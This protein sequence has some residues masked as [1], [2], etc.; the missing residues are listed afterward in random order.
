M[1]QE[2]EVTDEKYPEKPDESMGDCPFAPD[3]GRSF[4]SWQQDGR[5][6]PIST[7]W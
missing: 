3:Y 1:F 5:S 6:G 7:S 2:S 4:G